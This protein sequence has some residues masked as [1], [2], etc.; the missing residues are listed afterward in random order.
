MKKAGLRIFHCANNCGALSPHYTVGEARQAYL[1]R[2]MMRVLP[3]AAPFTLAPIFRRKILK[4][5]SAEIR[6]CSCVLKNCY[7][8]LNKKNAS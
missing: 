1:A 5:A 8:F 3:S 4:R 2:L 7:V 6:T